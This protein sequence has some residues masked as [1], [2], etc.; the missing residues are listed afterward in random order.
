MRKAVVGL[1]IWFALVLGVSVLGASTLDGCRSVANQIIC[2][3]GT[4]IVVNPV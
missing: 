1:A 2:S 3:P 4:T